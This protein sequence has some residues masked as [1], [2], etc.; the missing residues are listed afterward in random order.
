M[1]IATMKQGSPEWWDAKVGS[2]GGTRYGQ[3]VSTRKNRLIY[4]LINERLNGHIIQDDYTNDDIQF[5]NDNEP[6]ARELYIKKSGI[7]FKEIG[8][9]KSDYSTMHHASPDGLSDCGKVLEIKCTPN[10]E[11]HI[12]RFFEGVDSSYMPQIMNYFAVSDEVK[13]VHFVSYCPYREERPLIE[14]IFKA[15]YYKTE[16]MAARTKIAAIEAEV[17]KKQKEFIF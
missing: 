1:K 3:V 7:E 10:G 13:E 2:I 15:E 16:I 4:D 9:I 5:G 14:Y 17:I 8:M 11:I 6:I 12:Q